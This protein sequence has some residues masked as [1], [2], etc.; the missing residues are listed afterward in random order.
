MAFPAIYLIF[1]ALLFDIPLKACVGLLLSPSYWLLSLM[2]IASGWGLWE[3][4]RWSWYV[5][6]VAN[7]FVI[8]GNAYL[9]SSAGE[10]NHKVLAFLLS[11]ACILGLI[12]RV[13]RE[14]RVPYFL[15]K[16]RWWES[17]P[18]YKTVAPVRLKRTGN[19]VQECE[20]EILDISMGGCFVKLRSELHMDEPVSV[21]FDLFGLTIETLGIVVWRTQSTVT[22]PKGIGIKFSGFPRNQKRLMRA[23]CGRLRKIAILYRT[24]RYL[25]SP[26]EFNRR[27]TE[28]Q[29]EPLRIRRGEEGERTA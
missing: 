16:I 9:V 4:K 27:L 29:R 3:M 24:S 11:V 1:V 15:P 8:Y 14:V 12:Y 26:D 20:G 6:L 13:A 28:L 5:F 22:H 19:A 10:T 25:M 18:R 7:A 17:N 23:V 21:T 2:A